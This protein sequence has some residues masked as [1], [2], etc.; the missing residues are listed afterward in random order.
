ML[1][2]AVD[3][4]AIIKELKND[5][6]R[7]AH[8]Y[9]K[10]G[11]FP[12]ENFNKI[13]EKN[14]HTIN[15]DEKY[16]GG[17][18]GMEKTCD[19]LITIA[20]ACPATALCL[21]MHYYTLGGLKEILSEKLKKTVF[22]DVWENGEF[23]GSIGDPNILIFNN[24]SLSDLT[25]INYTKVCG[26][27]IVNGVKKYVSGSPRIRYLPIFCHCNNNY[28]YSD[29]VMVLITDIKAPGVVINNT[30]N[31]TAMKASHSNEIKYDNVFVPSENLVGR[32]G[33]GIEDTKELLY[34]FRLAL[35]SVY[36]G[37]ALS[38]YEYI[39]ELV[40]TKKDFPFKRNLAFNPRIQDLIAEIKIKLDVSH[41]YIKSITQ[42][43]DKEK[44]KY[45]DEFYLKTLG[46]KNFVSDTAIEIIH[47]CMQIEG[48]ASLNNGNLLERLHRDVSASVF[49]PPQNNALK[50]LLAMKVLG[51][52]P[53][54]KN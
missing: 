8:Y 39:L 2:K 40:K 33:H 29:G 42:Q 24:Q 19:F 47:K 38:A 11:K 46:V 37:V 45:N 9:D 25:S 7:R 51:I 22:T 49:H 32:E 12:Y 26:G 5:F 41:S 50:E 36:Q 48:M 28:E 13:V 1:E 10:T 35:V 34:W 17:N 21:A 31:Y 52:I 23:L 3:Y 6:K 30:W 4:D 27:Y 43:G 18:W 15:L 54:R 53:I 14:M 16:G 20:S 44:N